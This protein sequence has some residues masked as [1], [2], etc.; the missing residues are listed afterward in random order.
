MVQDASALISYGLKRPKD[1]IRVANYTV[2]GGR[3]ISTITFG[4]PRCQ[5]A[6]KG[7]R[8]LG[9]SVDVEAK[10]HD[11]LGLVETITKYLAEGRR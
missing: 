7:M 9:L 4:Q 6:L 8:A 2:D 1:R 5:T 10:Q 11:I 3:R